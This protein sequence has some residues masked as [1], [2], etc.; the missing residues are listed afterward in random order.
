[1]A[2]G[3]GRRAE[4]YTGWAIARPRDA[5][6]RAKGHVLVPMSFAW[7][8]AGAWKAYLLTVNSSAERAK[9]RRRGFRAVRVIVHEVG[10]GGCR[11]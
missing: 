4:P 7:T 8:R 2:D 5:A 10:D 11:A 1:M 9:H 3:R 6:E